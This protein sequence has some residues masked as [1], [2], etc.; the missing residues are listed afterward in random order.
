MSNKF[1]AGDVVQ[2]KSGGPYMTI[3]NIEENGRVW[4][5]WFDKD[6]EPKQQSYGCTVLQ[7]K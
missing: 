7:Q 6:G 1:N 2:V 3:E 5:V 4:C